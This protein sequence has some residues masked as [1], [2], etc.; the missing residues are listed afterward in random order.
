M[1]QPFLVTEVLAKAIT[2]EKKGIKI[3]KEEIKISMFADDMILYMEKV[4]RSDEPVQQSHRLQN[5]QSK[6]VTFLYTNNNL[7][8]KKEEIQIFN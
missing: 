8:E 1:L 7:T 6:T 2:E 3:V 4:V 5:Q